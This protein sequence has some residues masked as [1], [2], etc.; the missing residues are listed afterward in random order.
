MR[1]N[2]QFSDEFSIKAGVHQGAVLS[3]LLFIIIMEALSRKFR[4]GC[5]WELLYTDYLVSMAE[6]LEDLKKKLTI[7]KDN[8]EA[9]GLQV[10]VN[11]TKL[12]CTKHNSS[13]KSDPTKWS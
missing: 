11:K 9:K 7:W 13:V 10:N 2:G 3:P 8:I 1:L 5:P 6:T 12:V 4:V